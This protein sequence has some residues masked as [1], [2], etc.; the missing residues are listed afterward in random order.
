MRESLGI[1]QSCE[2]AKEMIPLLTQILATRL[3]SAIN[4][5]HRACGLVHTGIGI[6]PL[7]LSSKHIPRCSQFQPSLY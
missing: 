5:L 2:E 6:L 7:A 1:F 4:Y 3:L